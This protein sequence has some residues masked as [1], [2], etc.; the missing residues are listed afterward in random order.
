MLLRTVKRMWYWYAV[1]GCRLFCCVFFNMS[2]RGRENVPRKGPFVLVG[3][4]Q[5]FFD[6]LFCGMHL[7][8]HLYFLGRDTLFANRALGWLIGSMDTIPVRRGE[9]DFSAIRRVITVLRKGNGICVFPEATRSPNGRIASFKP[10]FGLLCR[11]SN[12]TVVPV[13][14]E[15]AYE[16]W[17]RHEKCFAPGARVVVSYGK[18]IAPEQ[19]R[20]MTDQ[21]LAARLTRQIRTMQNQCRIEQGKKPFDYKL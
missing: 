1:W 19:V 8:R 3:N 11:R 12:A 13:L 6:P 2:I 21:E 9:A 20:E 4:H 18:A 10:G 15:G 17:P 14:I 16:V 7:K 5:S